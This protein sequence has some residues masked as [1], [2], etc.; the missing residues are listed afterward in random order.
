MICLDTNYLVCSLISGSSEAKA[1]ATWLRKGE[2]LFAPSV[3]WY[4]F[5]CGPVTSAEIRLVCGF[6]AGGVIAFEEAQAATAAR[7]FNAAGRARRLRVDA[8]IAACAIEAGC[9]LAT[10]NRDDFAVFVP[11]G[12]V[13][14]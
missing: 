13:L 8:M 3:A 1:V 6:L 5:L 2:R 9:R 14:Y 12:L 4:E 10:S 11:F 7:L